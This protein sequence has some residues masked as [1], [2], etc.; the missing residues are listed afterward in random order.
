LFR[1]RFSPPTI[2]R[3]LTMTH[4]PPNAKHAIKAAV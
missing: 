1:Q 3:S 4:T 2:E